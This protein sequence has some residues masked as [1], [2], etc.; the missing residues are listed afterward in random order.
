MQNTCDIHPNAIILTSLISQR[1]K[2][3]N[4][5]H[6]SQKLCKRANECHELMCES[7]MKMFLALTEKKVS[8]HFFSLRQTHNLLSLIYE[9]KSQI[10]SSNERTNLAFC[11]WF[12]GLSSLNHWFLTWKW[13]ETYISLFQKQVYQLKFIQ[14]NMIWPES[15]CLWI[16][17]KGNCGNSLCSQHFGYMRGYDSQ[18]CSLHGS[19]TWNTE[20]LPVFCMKC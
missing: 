20:S 4:T 8:K 5:F 1:L 12:T 15:E 14:L 17:L 6:K 18:C 19:E 10:F 11:C 7:V 16:I 9:T 2:F 13:T 3:H